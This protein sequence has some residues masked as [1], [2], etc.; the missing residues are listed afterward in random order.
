MKIG[1][2]GN[3][4]IVSAALQAFCEA[5]IEV[6]A[7]WCRNGE[8]GKPLVEKYQIEKQ[9]TDYDAFLMDESFD[10]VYIGLINSLHYAYTKKALLAGKHVI[11]EKPFTSTYQEAN[12]LC[13][14]A[15]EKHLY[16][17]EAIMSRYSQNYQCINDALNRIGD[18]KMVQCNYSQYSRRFDAYLE[19]TVLPAFDPSLSGGALYDINIYN[20]HFTEGLFGMPGNVQY[21]A[22]KGFN[23]VDTS[24][25]LVMEYPDKHVVCT[26]AKDSASHNAIMIQGTKGYIIMDNRPGMIRN[27]TLHLHDGTEEKLDSFIENNPMRQEFEVMASV[28]NKQEYEK[29]KEWMQDSL[30]VMNILEEARRSCDLHFQADDIS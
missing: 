29:M 20:V 24:G 2:V 3:G 26:G 8:K 19:G 5:G 4:G 23:G 25:I 12:E 14:L 10:T 21:Y 30:C 18:I 28:V 1:I 27:V 13:T 6:H 9:Y 16:V 7:L 11:V 15:L 17:F 22:N